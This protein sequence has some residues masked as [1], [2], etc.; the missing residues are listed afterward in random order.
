MRRGGCARVFTRFVLFAARV[1][2]LAQRRCARTRV[3]QELG[4]HA[5]HTLA[6]AVARAARVAV[7]ARRQ[8]KF[9]WPAAVVKAQMKDKKNEKR[10]GL[11]IAGMNYFTP[12]NK[13]IKTKTVDKIIFIQFFFFF[14][15]LVRP[16][17]L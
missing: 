17:L 16:S 15:L 14:Y 3:G 11:Q 13:K 4:V 12:I 8:Y 6:E 1:A 7:V 10:N 2:L 9:K 5:A